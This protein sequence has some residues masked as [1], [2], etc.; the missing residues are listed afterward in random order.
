MIWTP[1]FFEAGAA[2]LGEVWS[3]AAR[4]GAV[5][6]DQARQDVADVAGISEVWSSAE[7]LGVA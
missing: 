1:R 6:C 2:R 5:Q 3:G 4:T 7:R